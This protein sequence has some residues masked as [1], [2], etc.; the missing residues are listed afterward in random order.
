MK[1]MRNAKRLVLLTALCAIISCGGGGGGGKGSN[2]PRP[3]NPPSNPSNPGD[4]GET[5]GMRQ[6]ES[7]YTRTKLEDMTDKD[8]LKDFRFK[9]AVDKNEI[10]YEEYGYKAIVDS[11]NF[12][13]SSLT[14]MN[15]NGITYSPNTTPSVQKIV[16]KD[17]GIGLN[18]ESDIYFNPSARDQEDKDKL[19]YAINKIITQFANKF[20]NLREVE[21]NEGGTFIAFDGVWNEETENNDRH[22]KHVSLR[23]DSEYEFGRYDGTPYGVNLKITGSGS[24]FKYKDFVLK[25]DEDVDLDVSSN[26]YYKMLK[27]KGVFYDFWENFKRN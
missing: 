4:P 7:R 9:E 8:Y 1:K 17:G 15:T 13:P 14:T 6:A 18:V 22:I 10:K 16:I 2:N 20:S 23:N 3:T 19:D 21:I 25:I 12:Y 5:I 11:D 26:K 24:L 27:M